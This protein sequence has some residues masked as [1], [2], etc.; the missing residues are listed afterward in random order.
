MELHSKQV[1]KQCH[2]SF[3]AQKYVHFELRSPC[4]LRTASPSLEPRTN[5]YPTD[6]ERRCD[7]SRDTGRLSS[8]ISRREISS[9]EH[10]DT[11]SHDD[12]SSIYLGFSY[13]NLKIV[14]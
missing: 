14:Y 7:R 4:E 11:S 2:S 6:C 1:K 10:L 3:C 5:Y 9:V 8:V 13:V 12:P